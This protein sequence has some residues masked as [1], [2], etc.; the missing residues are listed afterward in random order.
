MRDHSDFLRLALSRLQRH[1]DP[2]PHL[3]ALESLSSAADM[4]TRM[5]T[6]HV[7]S[8]VPTVTVQ[9]PTTDRWHAVGIAEFQQGRRRAAT[10]LLYTRGTDEGL[11]VET[12]SM[13][14]TV[15]KRC[16]HHL[17]TRSNVIY[18]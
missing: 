18:T 1:G 12:A 2:T 8:A 5:G 15:H 11:L 14:R 9:S 13:E 17:T 16:A 4:H 10:A 3:G 6:L 7:Y